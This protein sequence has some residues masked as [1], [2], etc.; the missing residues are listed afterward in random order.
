MLRTS[1]GTEGACIFSEKR[2][3]TI[4]YRVDHATTKAPVA[5]IATT[6]C[7][8]STSMGGG[9]LQGSASRQCRRRQNIAERRSRSRYL[10]HGLVPARRRRNFRRRG[11]WR[12]RR[13]RLSLSQSRRTGYDR[14]TGPAAERWRMAPCNPDHRQRLGQ[15]WPR[16]DFVDIELNLVLYCRTSRSLRNNPSQ[17]L[18]HQ[19]VR[20]WQFPSLIRGA[21]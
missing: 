11:G 2:R 14:R 18:S 6:S 4:P 1:I 13:C 5:S 3:A 8:W 19:R 9:R 21:L 20:R 7:T 16:N 10:K 17:A 12:R 15:S